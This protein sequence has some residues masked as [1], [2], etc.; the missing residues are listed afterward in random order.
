MTAFTD[1]LQ[2][3]IAAVDSRL[4]IGLDPRPELIQGPV[5]DF[6]MRAIEEGAPHAA[7]FKPNSAY[8]EALGPEGFSLLARVMAAIPE[9]IPTVL[10]V[11]RADIPA[12]QEYYARSAY[13]VFGADAVTLNPY[14]GFD[15]LA[16]FLKRPGKAAYLLAVTSN[17][18]AADLQLKPADGRPLYA[19]VFD[20]AARAE[21]D[22]ELPGALGFVVGLTQGDDALW[23]AVPDAPLLLPGLGAQGGTLDGLA[24]RPRAAPLLINSSRSILYHADAPVRERARITKERI[25]DALPR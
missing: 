3:R 13:D 20:W 14:M 23:D 6:L 18:G 12:T 17:P 15:S 16:P 10:D 21:R 9:D 11:K 5:E 22:P 2:A 24:R 8:F 25:N 1:K 19:H 7:A 4:C